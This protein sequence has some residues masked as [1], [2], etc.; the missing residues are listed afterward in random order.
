MLSSPVL[1][2]LGTSTMSRALYWSLLNSPDG[3]QSA[4]AGTPVVAQGPVFVQPL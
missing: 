2:M 4:N 1:K 3:Q